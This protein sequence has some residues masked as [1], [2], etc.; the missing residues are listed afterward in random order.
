M[1][2]EDSRPLKKTRWEGDEIQFKLATRPA[3]ELPSPPQQLV[4]ERI[5]PSDH[6]NPQAKKKEIASIIAAAN[7]AAEA[8][9]A[10]LAAVAAAAQHPPEVVR[11]KPKAPK[12]SQSKEERERNKEKRLL[13]LVGAVVV[14]CMS[15]YAGKMDNDMFKKYAKEV[16]CF[17]ASPLTCHSVTHPISPRVV[18][19]CHCR[20]GE[21]IV[22]LQR[23]PPGHPL[24]RKNRQDKKVCKGIYNQSPSQTRE[25]KVEA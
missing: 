1:P 9:A 6:F 14:K 15:K 21:E 23:G 16:R 10:R 3:L 17:L 13:K 7:A 25:I 8:E 5:V 11:K 18:N 19:S 12:K 2:Q 20:E 4:Q 24:R 22:F